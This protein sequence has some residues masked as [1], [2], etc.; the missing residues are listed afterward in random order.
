M[1]QPNGVNL[2]TRLQIAF[3]AIAAAIIGASAA[4]VQPPVKLT[5]QPPS[6]MPQSN[7]P[8]KVVGTINYRGGHTWTGVI[9]ITSD[10]VTYQDGVITSEPTGIPQGIT[11]S[12]NRRNV[13]LRN[14]TLKGVG[15]GMNIENNQ[16]VDDLVIDNCKFLD[17]RTPGGD[18]QDVLIRGRGYGIFAHAGKNW[19]IRDSVFQ[20]TTGVPDPTRTTT[21]SQYAALLGDI[22]GL[23]V[24]RTRFSNTGQACAWLMFVHAAVFDE[25]VFEGGPIRIGARPNDMPGIEKGDCRNIVFRKCKFTFGSHENWPAGILIFPGTENITFE[26]CEITT[27]ADSGWWLEVDERLTSNIRWKNCKWNGKPVEGYTGIR[28]SMSPEQ[29]RAR[30]VGPA[31]G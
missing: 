9:Q 4:A 10:H 17:C 24:S 23:N 15:D 3:Q 12:G 27:I 7:A 2:N 22:H 31:E 19:T 11:F 18:S 21:C 1:H 29:M 16:S 14:L 8:G 26:D 20:T 25:A 28:S 13:T 6:S 30:N 5:P